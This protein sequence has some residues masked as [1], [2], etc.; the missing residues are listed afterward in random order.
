MGRVPVESLETGGCSVWDVRIHPST[1]DWAIACVYDGYLFDVNRAKKH[2]SMSLGA[3]DFTQ[4]RYRGHES[5]CYSMAWTKQ[6][7]LNEPVVLTTSFYDNT[8]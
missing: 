4:T 7:S 5:I 3:L 6:S 1:Q 8:V 2:E